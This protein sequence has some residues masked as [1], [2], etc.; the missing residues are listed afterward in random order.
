MSTNLYKATAL[1]LVYPPVS[2]QEAE[3]LEG[4]REVADAIKTSDFYMIA[5]REEIT[6]KNVRPDGLSFDIHLGEHL[7]E[8]VGIDPAQL[9]PVVDSGADSLILEWGEKMLRV[10]DETRPPSPGSLLDW[11]TTEKLIFDR[12][13]DLP[14]I[15]GFDQY[16]TA[17]TYELLYV[18]IAKIGDTYERLIARAHKARDRVLSNERQR[19]AGARV[20]DEI[21]LFPFRLATTI[22]REYSESSDFSTVGQRPNVPHKA[23]VA[24]AEKAFVKLLL[25]NY[26]RTRFTKYPKGADGLYDVGLAGYSFAIR[27]NITFSTPSGILHGGRDNSINFLSENADVIVVRGNEVVVIEGTQP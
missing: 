19:K 18:G 20:T 9:G 23:I 26:N 15:I 21:Y 24:D 22:V 7:L 14:G 3:W 8:T 2:T 16:R 4:D 12:S 11:F 5:A 27:E 25:P 17:G 1:E 10:W 6:F 13:R